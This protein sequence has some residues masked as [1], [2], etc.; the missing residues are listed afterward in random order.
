MEIINKVEQSGLIQ[1]DLAIFKSKLEMVEIDLKENLWQELVLK[2]KDFRNW[3]QTNDWSVYDQKAVYIHCSA[4]AIIPTWAYMLVSS[5]LSKRSIF[6]VVG[7]KVDLEKQ[8]ISKN[9]LDFD[10]SKY[11]EGKIIIKG[12]SELFDPAWVMVEVLKHL[13]PIAKSIMYGEPCST[14]PIFKRKS[15]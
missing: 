1:L 4:D 13:Q 7:T 14:V 5:E 12:C 10:I 9:I 15:V 3:I 2:E 6:H 8:L 11:Q